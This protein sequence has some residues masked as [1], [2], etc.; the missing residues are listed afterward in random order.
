MSDFRIS[1]SHGDYSVRVGL[2]V[3]QDLV[4]PAVVIVDPVVETLVPSLMPDPIRVEARESEK[5]LASCERV[6]AAM[7][8]RGL[9]RGG[10]V[11]AIGGGVV[12]DIATLSCSLY[13]RGVPWTYVPT[14]LMSMADS[15]IGGKSSINAGGI[16]NLVG[17]FYPPTEVLVDPMFIEGLPT[18]ARVAGIAEAVK[19]SYARGPE[20]FGDFLA[21]DSALE[22]GAD[23]STAALIEHVLRA[24]KWFVEVDEFD[25]AERQLLNFGHSFGHAWEAACDFAVPHGVGVAIGMLAAVRHPAAGRSALSAELE[26]FTLALV[27]QIRSE[28]AEAAAV[29]DSGVFRRAL[30][31]DKKNTKDALRLVLPDESG[32][33]AMTEHPL[34][35]AQL[36]IAEDSLRWALE[37]VVS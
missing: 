5:T 9:R 26:R 13:M 19:I 8:A 14:T 34:N 24:K 31:T 12:Q 22:P 36:R 20:S 25:R 2:G 11:V 37:D 23:V 29:T 32:R 1:S 4:D 17:N 15:C 33:L 21:S 27:A 6:L 35:D 3:L 10:T 16:K 18:R 30:R 28:V 7:N